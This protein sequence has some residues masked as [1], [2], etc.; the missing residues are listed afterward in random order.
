M[1]AEK[2]ILSGDVIV[3]PTDT[4]YGFGVNAS[5][6]KAV[7]KLNLIKKRRSPISVIAANVN[8]VKKWV[9]LNPEEFR[10]A[11]EKLGGP[12]TVILPVKKGIV[13]Q[14]VSAEDGSLGIR[15]PEHP[16][17]PNLVR[18]LGFPIT[19][20]SVNRTGEPPLND[21]DIISEHFANDIDLLLDE[22][23][24]PPSSGSK[25]YKWNNSELKLIRS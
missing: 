9:C 20:T 19:T 8:M 15:I 7:H 12:T 1:L 3:Y 6:N 23:V 11:R 25:I 10:I 5:D 13:I 4:L 24:L 17:G 22:G 16:F 14:G 2:A 21:P 18:N